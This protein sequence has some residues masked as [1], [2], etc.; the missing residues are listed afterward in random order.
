MIKG[1]PRAWTRSPLEM[2]VR[3][4]NS[5]FKPEFLTSGHSVSYQISIIALLDTIPQFIRIKRRCRL[6]SL[7]PLLD[8]P[9]QTFESDWWVKIE[10][11]LSIIV[12]RFM[13]DLAHLNLCLWN[14][15]IN[16]FTHNSL[17]RLWIVIDLNFLLLVHQS[18]SMLYQFISLLIKNRWNLI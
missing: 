5:G 15:F 8:L 3:D 10:H 11:S 13:L 4:L 18:L 16:I 12:F 2:E 14:L 1:R 6:N 9:I 7:C 17:N